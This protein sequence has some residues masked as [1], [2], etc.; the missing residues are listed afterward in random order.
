M[1]VSGVNRLR[2]YDSFRRL[3]DVVL[4]EIGSRLQLQHHPAGTTVFAQNDEQHDVFVV[5]AGHLRLTTYTL[6]GREVVFHDLHPGDLVGELSA[7]D[8]APRGVNMIAISDAELGRLAA[9]DF[10]NL[11]RRHPEFAMAILAR[12]TRI[13]RSLNRRVH[14]LTAPV[15]TRVCAELFRL[16]AFSRLSDNTARLVPAPKHDDIANRINTHR[17]AVSRTLGELQRRQIIR[18][19]RGELVVL[20]MTALDRLAEGGTLP[21]VGTAGSH[22]VVASDKA[23]RH[24]GGG[25]PGT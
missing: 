9:A 16:A 24:R 21:P 8:G 17:E 6:A 4:A 22:T 1:T 12:L 20:D 10:N 23:S 5:L 2:Q 14:L 7:I 11:L 13:I 15:P 18:R 3:D 25:P 19:G